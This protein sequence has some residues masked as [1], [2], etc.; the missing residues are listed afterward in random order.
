[1]PLKVSVVPIGKVADLRLDAKRAQKVIENVLDM[2]AEAIRADYHV[3]TR[4]WSNKP[5]FVIEKPN[6]WERLIYTENEIYG[7]VSEGTPVRYATMTPDFQA[8]TAPRVIASGTGRGGVA[9]VSKAHPRP[10][11]KAREFPE[12]IGRKWDKEAP[13]QIERALASELFA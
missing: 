2:T 1:M 7:Y 6:P 12:T 13:R 10:G 5:T 11:I 9:F 4:T 3:T 8:K